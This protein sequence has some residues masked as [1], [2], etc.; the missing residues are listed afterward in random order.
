MGINNN[1]VVGYW[2]A[3]CFTHLQNGATGI[4]WGG[5]VIDEKTG[6]QHTTTQM[7]SGHFPQE[8]YTKASYFKNV[9][10]LDETNNLRPVPAQHQTSVTEAHCYNIKLGQD[11]SWGSYFFYGGPGRNRMCP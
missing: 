10:I 11:S 9:Q 4:M 1:I 3:S 5:E 7:G 6:D 8:G 2:A